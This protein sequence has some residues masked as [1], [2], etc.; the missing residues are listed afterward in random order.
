MQI[1]QR[2][3]QLN[4]Q[5]AGGRQHSPQHRVLVALAAQA[6]FNLNDCPCSSVASVP[7]SCMLALLWKGA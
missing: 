2:R 5:R 6:G 4:Q 1:G 3:F 7:E